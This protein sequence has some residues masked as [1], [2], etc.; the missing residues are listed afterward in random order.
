MLTS[1]IS[2]QQVISEQFGIEKA[3]FLSE[4]ILFEFNGE[5]DHL[6]A[7]E[8]ALSVEDRL[9]KENLLKKTIKSFFSILIEGIQNVKL[10]GEPDASKLK[11]SFILVAKN[12]FLT[13]VTGNVVH[14]EQIQKLTQ[15]I[16]LL[17]H[18]TEDELKEYYMQILTQGSLSKKGGAGLGLITLRSKSKNLLSYRFTPIDEEHYLFILQ[19]TLKTNCYEKNDLGSNA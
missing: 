8:V 1:N 13:L 2:I 17:N 15:K 9:Q 16:I 19:T 12:E 4:A 11:K 6:I 10:H 5:S 18:F 7:D 3:L 14:K